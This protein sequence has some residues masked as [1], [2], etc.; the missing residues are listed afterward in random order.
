MKYDGWAETT[1]PRHIT[2]V[3]AILADLHARDEIY[4]KTHK[5]FYSVRQEQFLTDRD[6][7]EAGEFGPEWGEV[8]EIEEENYYFKLS[9]HTPWLREFLEKSDDTIL[10]AFR[11]SELINAL[12]KKHRNGSLHFPPQGAPH[13]GH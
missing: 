12:E 4:K 6:R 2:C 1:D 5:G 10:P 7:N 11:K 13:L 9:N 3:Q 8:T